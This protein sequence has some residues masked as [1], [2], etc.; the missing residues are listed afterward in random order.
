MWMPPIEDAWAGKVD[1]WELLFGTWT[2]YAFL[3]LWFEKV[4]R[5]PFA[6][7]R[8]VMLTF[9]GA[10]A[11][12]I[13]HYFQ[14][15]PFWLTFINLYTLGFLIAW[16]FIAVREAQRSSGWVV[17]A[18]ASA[19]LFTVAFIAFEQAARFGVERLGMHEFCIMTLSF[20]GFVGIIAW[21]GHASAAKPGTLEA[22][23]SHR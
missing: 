19:V 1:F 16:W 10:S 18:M 4:L 20:F 15:A 2:V 17:A 22:T 3:V 12:W 6:E 8:Y 21:R 9:L 23:P 5:R 11:F 13:N 14:K 7:W